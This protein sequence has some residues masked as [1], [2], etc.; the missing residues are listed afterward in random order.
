MRAAIFSRRAFCAASVAAVFS[1]AAAAAFASAAFL[2][3]ARCCLGDGP[4]SSSSLYCLFPIKNQVH[5]ED[6]CDPDQEIFQTIMGHCDHSPLTN[7]IFDFGALAAALG[8]AALLA[9]ILGADGKGISLIRP[10]PAMD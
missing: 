4:L 2:A 6:A 3:S 10:D 5:N 1:A 8:A 7:A 9:E